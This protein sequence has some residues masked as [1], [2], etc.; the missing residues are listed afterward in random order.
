MLVLAAN[1]CTLLT[2]VNYSAWTY[3]WFCILLSALRSLWCTA[4]A[5]TLGKSD[6]TRRDYVRTITAAHTMTAPTPLCG[7]PR[8]IAPSDDRRRVSCAG[9]AYAAGMF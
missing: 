1:I 6:V 4:G 9:L 2:D 3:T 8:R 5:M 7:P